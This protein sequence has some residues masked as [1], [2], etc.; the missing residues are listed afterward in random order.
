MNMR[1][2]MKAMLSLMLL[3]CGGSMVGMNQPNTTTTT[4]PNTTTT[5]QPTQPV[6]TTTTQPNTTTDNRLTKL[7]LALCS[8]TEK[9]RTFVAN[10]KWWMIGGGVAVAGIITAVLMRKSIGSA[11]AKFSPFVWNKGKTVTPK[12]LP[13]P[14]SSARI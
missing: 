14:V 11:F 2:T 13:T 6:I 3:V 5:T 10:H 4:Q 9:P 1:S 12:F 7:W 8:H